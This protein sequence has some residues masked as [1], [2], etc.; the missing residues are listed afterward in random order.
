MPDEDQ[1][2]NNGT[3]RPSKQQA[4]EISQWKLTG[5]VD[6]GIFLIFLSFLSF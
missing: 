1:I 4:N 6:F 2:E 3:T 5:L